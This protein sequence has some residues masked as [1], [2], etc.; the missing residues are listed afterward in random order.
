VLGLERETE[1]HSA[2]PT[3]AVQAIHGI[4]EQSE[5]E[6][7]A[8]VGVLSHDIEKSEHVGGKKVAF[9]L[10]DKQGM[11]LGEGGK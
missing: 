7:E 8:V 4:A 2:V 10:M 6:G 5:R 11:V 3:R 1:V 9:N